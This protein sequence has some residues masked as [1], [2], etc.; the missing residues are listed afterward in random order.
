LFTLSSV[1]LTRRKNRLPRI[2]SMTCDLT[3]TSCGLMTGYDD[4]VRIH[5]GWPSRPALSRATLRYER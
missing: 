5:R 4:F 1:S 2:T 3:C